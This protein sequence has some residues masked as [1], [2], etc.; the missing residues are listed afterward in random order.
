MCGVWVGC[1]CGY[2]SVVWY[3]CG[4]KCGS[5]Y[6]EWALS[7]CVKCGCKSGWECRVEC[8]VEWV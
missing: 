6:G 1:G 5:G 8:C 4:V 3:G 7:M 2:G